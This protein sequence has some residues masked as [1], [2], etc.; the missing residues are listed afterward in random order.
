MSYSTDEPTTTQS[1]YGQGSAGALSKETDENAE[2]VFDHLV[3]I[4]DL[5][6]ARTYLIQAVAVDKAGNRTESD[7]YTVLTARKRESF[8]QLVVSN[9]EE[10]F[11]WLGNLRIGR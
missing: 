4:S 8:L 11:S 1:K 3:V 6:P 10:T 9:L 5:D 2:L 7:S